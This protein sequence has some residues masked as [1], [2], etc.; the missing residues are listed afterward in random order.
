MQQEHIYK[1]T[2]FGSLKVCYGH[3]GLWPR[4]GGPKD[5]E[6][7]LNSF[8]T[9][10]D[11]DMFWQ[12][13]ADISVWKCWSLHDSRLTAMTSMLKPSSPPTCAEGAWHNQ[14]YPSKCRW[15]WWS[16]QERLMFGMDIMKTQLVWSLF[17]NAN[18]FI[19]CC[20]YHKPPPHSA[21]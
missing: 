5:S 8:L 11:K 14:S 17:T 20:F 18:L 7:T 9:K 19:F 2:F 12:I 16:V 1:N 10:R 6:N 15:S 13:G 4:W 21:V 3:N